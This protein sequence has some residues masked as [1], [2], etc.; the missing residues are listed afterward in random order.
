MSKK[1]IDL[2]FD[3][4]PGPEN[5]RLGQAPQGP[6]FV[7]AEN[8]RGESIRAGHWIKRGDGKWAL[9]IMPEELIQT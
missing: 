4:P 3:G 7:E 1:Y 6:G 9:R 8:E 2:V 5:P